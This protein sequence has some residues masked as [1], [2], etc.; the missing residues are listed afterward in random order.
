M[1]PFWSPAASKKWKY[2][3][4]GGQHGKIKLRVPVDGYRGVPRIPRTAV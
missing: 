4:Y 2:E 1:E 3:E